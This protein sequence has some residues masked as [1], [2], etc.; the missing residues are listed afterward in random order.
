MNYTKTVSNNSKENSKAE[1]YERVTAPFLEKASEKELA[2]HSDYSKFFYPSSKGDELEKN[3]IELL[4]RQKAINR[5]IKTAL[6]DAS[7]MFTG[8]GKTVF[9]MTINPG[10]TF[11]INNM[12]GVGGLT[13]SEDA[14][15]LQIDP[16]YTDDMLKYTTVH[17]YYHSVFLES[18]KEKAYTLLD[19]A[20]FEGKADSFAEILYPDNSAPWLEPL[21]EEL[22]KPTF[23]EFKKQI[24]STNSEVYFE[25]LKVIELKEFHYGQIIKLALK[26]PKVT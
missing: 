9:V 25:F 13:L 14:I 2:I 12:E 15:L 17:E 4:K 5:L 11:Y 16:S 20:I 10:K 18:Y 19:A 21:K 7:E 22:R 6:I 26:L 8:S 23:N 24:D 3:T 1:Y